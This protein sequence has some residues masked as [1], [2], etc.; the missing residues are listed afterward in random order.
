M[1]NQAGL[2]EPL[3]SGEGPGSIKSELPGWGALE[4][5]IGGMVRLK[6]TA[7]TDCVVHAG[8]ILPSWYLCGE[9]YAVNLETLETEGIHDW[10][11]KEGVSAHCKVDEET[12]EML[13][14]N[15]QRS[16]MHYGIVPSLHSFNY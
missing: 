8:R 14:F 6:D 3:L 10:S 11:P 4:G 15:Y 7:S 13:F 12:G 9:A 1:H 2:H 16:G 5:A